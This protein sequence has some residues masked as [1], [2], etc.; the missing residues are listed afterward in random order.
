MKIVHMADSHLG[1]SSFSKVDRKGRNLME[2]MV[3][4]GFD[5]AID[6]ILEIHPDAVVHSGDVFQYVRPR[7]RPLYVFKKGI[8][9]LQDAGIPA[10]IISG[11]HDAPKGHSAISPFYIFEGMRDVHIAHKYSYEAFEIEDHTFHCIPFCLSPKDYLDEF[12]K[13]ERT[14]RDVLVM[15]GLVEALQNHK[16]LHL[17]GHEI[18]DSL[19]KSDFDYIALGHYHGQA[20]ISGNAWYSGSI[21]YFDFGEAL[22]KKGILYVDLETCRASSVEVCGRYMADHPPVDCTGLSSEEILER[23]E[24]LCR[25]AGPEDVIRITLRN[26]SRPAYRGVDAKRLNRLMTQV[27]HLM[28]RPEYVEDRPGEHAGPVDAVHMPMEFRR[29]M[30][31]NS[32]GVPRAIQEQVVSYG[33]GLIQSAVESRRTGVVNAPQ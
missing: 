24:S 3:Y 7:I 20:Q 23:I 27:L 11:N 2:E 15:H 18:K 29:F 26:V 25:S 28:I 5:Q 31:Q 22:E 30:S 16:H 9:R 10:V 6:K 14:S 8:E 32:G 19:L 12:S 17:G 4:S 13:I 33:E 21:E 1:F